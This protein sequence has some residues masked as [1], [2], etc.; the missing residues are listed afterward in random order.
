V[1]ESGF[2]ELRLLVMFLTKPSRPGGKV[3]T[4]AISTSFLRSLQLL[5]SQAFTRGSI[6]NL[7]TACPRARYAGSGA[8][9]QTPH[10]RAGCRRGLR[11][12]L[13]FE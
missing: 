5:S 4:T 8:G 2:E 12:T 6:G 9:V 7:R 1:P 10:A 13:V 11:A 3:R